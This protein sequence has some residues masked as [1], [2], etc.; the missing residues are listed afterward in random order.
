MNHTC[1]PLRD[2]GTLSGHTL[3]EW[4]ERTMSCVEQITGA[5]YL[6]KFQLECKFDNAG[7]VKEKTENYAK[8]LS[9]RTLL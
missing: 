9:S 7:I 2:V 3:A 5:G 1:Q 4:Y 6:V 8:S